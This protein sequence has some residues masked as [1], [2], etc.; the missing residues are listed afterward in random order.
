MTSLNLIGYWIMSLKGDPFLPP[1]EFVSDEEST[2]RQIVANYLDS[3]TMA[4]A[5]RSTEW[6]RFL[7][8][9]DNGSCELSDGYWIWPEGLSHYVRDHNVRLPDEFVADALAGRPSH[10]MP[11]E[12][13]CD[14][15]TDLSFWK[16]WCSRNRSFSLMAHL[17]SARAA[18]DRDL[19]RIVAEGVAQIVSDDER[20]TGVSDSICLWEGCPN[21]ALKGFDLCAS[22]IAR[23]LNKHENVANQAYREGLHRVLKNASGADADPRMSCRPV[24]KYVQ[25]DSM[26][27]VVYLYTRNAAGEIELLHLKDRSR[28]LAGL[29][30]DRKRFYGGQAA[31]SL[32]LRLFPTLV[33]RDLFAEGEDLMALEG[34]ARLVLANIS[35]FTEQAGADGETLRLRIQNILDGID[36][37][38]QTGAGVA[39]AIG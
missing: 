34:E 12:Q 14:A 20:R 11:I 21:F 5:Y 10:V 25:W 28:E 19:P 27:L 22:C 32:G 7:C 17:E 13:R 15:P 2:V 9:G 35:R 16:E 33:E 8:R 4:R 3:G 29:E 37:A 1:Q 36:Q 31:H 38:R 23:C 18:I 26:K 30:V 24:C 39:I 6:C